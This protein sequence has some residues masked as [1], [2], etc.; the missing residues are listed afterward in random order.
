MWLLGFEHGTFQV[1]AA[2]LTTEPSRQPPRRVFMYNTEVTDR[3]LDGFN[4]GAG[5]PLWWPE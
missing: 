3:A 2:L 4:V 5:L 1:Q